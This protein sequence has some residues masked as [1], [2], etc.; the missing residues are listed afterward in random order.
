MKKGEE[1]E[2]KGDKSPLHIFLGGYAFVSHSAD[3]P[4]SFMKTTTGLHAHK[5]KAPEPSDYIEQIQ[6]KVLIYSLGNIYIHSFIYHLFQSKISTITKS[7]LA[8]HSI[9][10]LSLLHKL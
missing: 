8:S 4:A 7:T 10:F 2:K 1:E 5:L 3:S 9:F 6:V